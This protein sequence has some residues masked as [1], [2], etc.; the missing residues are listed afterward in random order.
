MTGLARADLMHLPVVRLSA[1]ER[2]EIQALGCLPQPACSPADWAVMVKVD[3]HVV[4]H[5]GILYRV[6]RVGKRRMLVGG[7]T[8]VTTL[9]NW[10]GRGYARASIQSA[11]DFIRTMLAAPFALTICPPDAAAFYEHLGWQ[12]HDE[13]ITADLAGRSTIMHGRVA[14]TLDCQ[15]NI[16]W[17]TGSIDLDGAPW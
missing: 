5:M 11:S 8:P 7:F 3:R 14:A 1:A 6:I 10:R 2:A 15:P 12:I 16:V 4:T 13:P 9:E 17:P